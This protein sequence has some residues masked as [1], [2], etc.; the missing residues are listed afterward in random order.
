MSVFG[1]RRDVSPP[2]VD[3]RRTDVAPFAKDDTN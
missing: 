1:E 2:V 3:N